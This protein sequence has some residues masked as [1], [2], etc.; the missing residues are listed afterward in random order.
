M[1]PGHR[2]GSAGHTRQ[3]RAGTCAVPEKGASALVWGDKSFK[4][5][6]DRHQRWDCSSTSAPQGNSPW[7][8]FKV[9]FIAGLCWSRGRREHDFDHFWFLQKLAQPYV[10]FQCHSQPD[11]NPGA[12][13]PHFPNAAPGR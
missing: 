10:Y 4:E 6:D 5:G 13:N 1:H 11:N 7:S 8:Q 9:R 2:A 3:L 12:P